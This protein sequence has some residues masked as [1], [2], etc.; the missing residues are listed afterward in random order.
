[1]KFI[2]N[3][4]EIITDVEFIYWFLNKEYIAV[5]GTNGKTQ[6]YD[7]LVYITM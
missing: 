6:C 1:M 7:T 2:E 3:N 5:T 4:V